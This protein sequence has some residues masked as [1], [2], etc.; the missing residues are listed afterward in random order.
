[1]LSNEIKVCDKIRIL[2]N[3]YGIEMTNKLEN[4]VNDMCNLSKGIR[5]EGIAKGIAQ[6]M[7]LGEEKKQLENI[8]KMVKNLGISIEKAMA[9]LEIPESEIGR[10]LN[11]LKG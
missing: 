3:N 5:D 2:E 4:E 10:Y 7:I 8:Q 6:G 11:L 1:M 9:V